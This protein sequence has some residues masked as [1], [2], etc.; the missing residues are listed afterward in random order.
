[1]TSI[2]HHFLFSLGALNQ[3]TPG[4]SLLSVRKKVLIQDGL[5]RA[6]DINSL[7]NVKYYIS[8]KD[9][10]NAMAQFTT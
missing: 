10:W 9:I 6:R 1:M 8:S 7:V 2:Q 5:A 4:I 3:P